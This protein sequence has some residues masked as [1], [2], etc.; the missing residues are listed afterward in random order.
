MNY[1][2]IV[3]YFVIFN[4]EQCLI[5]KLSKGL[6]QGD[7]FSPYLFLIYAEGFF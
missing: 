3:S 6:R 7:P 2:T 1:V 5:F 4:G